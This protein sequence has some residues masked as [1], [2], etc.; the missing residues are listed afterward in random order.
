MITEKIYLKNKELFEKDYTI[1][2]EKIDKAIENAVSKIERNIV[3]FSDKY[4]GV[5]YGDNKIQKTKYACK[6][7]W[8]KPSG[9]WLSGLYEGIYWLC[10]ELTGDQKFLD[11]ANRWI[12]Y[13]IDREQKKHD[14]FCHDTGFVFSPSLVASY[15]LTGNKEAY[16]AAL[17]AAE[18]FYNH[19]YCKEG[20]F[21]LRCDDGTKGVEGSCRTMMDTML[22]VPLLFWAGK[23]T[24][25][26]KYT[27]AAIAQCETT[28]INL[29][30]NDA[31]S[32]HHFQYDINT[33]EPK[34]GL[35]YQGHSDES[36]WS[37]GQSWGIMGYPIAYAY[38]GNKEYID[39]HRDIT[40]YF[41]NHLQSDLLPN[42]DFDYTSDSDQRDSSAAAIA[43]CGMLEMIKHLPDSAEQK[44]IFKN[45]SAR[46][47]E[48][49]ID[50]CTEYEEDFDGLICKVWV[51]RGGEITQETPKDIF[52]LYGDYPY[53]EALMRYK[54]PEWNM[55]W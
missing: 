44:K 53:L 10:W 42:W 27:D 14:M 41:L 25:D 26:Q 35:T 43:V 52:A 1:S 34:Y 5:E 3:R 46:I 9:E 13:F 11:V 23:E 30:R 17:D 12:P 19:N 37:R 24:R 22:N 36:T 2:A 54:N 18:Y 50:N 21:I 20:G 32:Y 39:I 29:L 33:F 15:K 7:F 49:L 4:P 8:G 28:K 55:Y 6:D 48:S 45:A 47:L 51:G 31:S 40:Y 16:N 38:T